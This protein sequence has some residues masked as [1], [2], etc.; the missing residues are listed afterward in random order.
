MDIRKNS[1]IGFGLVVAVVLAA[2]CAT[3]DGVS[4]MDK[5]AYDFGI[6]EKPEGY[7]SGTDRIMERLEDVAKTEMRRMNSSGRHGDVQFREENELEGSYYKESKVYE[8]YLVL[9]ARSLSRSSQSDRGY[10]GF[11]EYTYEIFQGEHRPTQA[12]AAAQ[13]ANIKTGKRGREVLRYT[14]SAS[15]TWDGAAGEP[16]RL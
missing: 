10:V 12:E 9:D 5:V 1:R 14:F 6:G 16:S 7:V 11:V 15:G 2:G 4:V 13:S 3:D 8:S